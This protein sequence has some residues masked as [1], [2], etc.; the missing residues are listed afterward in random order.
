MLFVSGILAQE[1]TAVNLAGGWDDFWGGLKGAPGFE[2]IA[3]LATAL[4]AILVVGAV[5]KWLWEK[6]RGGGGGGKGSEGILWAL[7]LGAVLAAPGG[8]IPL[9]LTVLDFVANGI[10]GVFERTSGS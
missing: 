1:S 6:R 8:L 7:A 4:G 9:L 5:L 2:G 10:I 3:A